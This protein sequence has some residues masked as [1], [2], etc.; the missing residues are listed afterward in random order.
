MSKN[1]QPVQVIQPQQALCPA[2]MSVPHA[3]SFLPLDFME[4]SVLT[5]HQLHLSEDTFTDSLFWSEDFN[6]PLIKA[7]Y[8]RSY[9]DVN[10]E[11]F[12]LTKK[13]F[14]KELP[15]FINHCSQKAAKGFGTIPEK[16][17]RGMKIYKQKITFDEARKRIDGVYKPFHNSLTSLIKETQAKFGKCFLLD[18]H[19]MP[20]RKGR[21]NFDI[22]I[23]NNFGTSCSYEHSRILQDLCQSQGF[24]VT[25]N[26]PFSGGYTVCHY[27]CPELG[28][29][30]VQIEVL[31]SL[32]MNEETLKKT[33]NFAEIQNRLHTVI[34]QFT[35]IL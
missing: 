25:F 29:S 26:N 15:V 8:S 22:I 13:M 24:S 1:V 3:G 21:K 11:P 9:V 4:M 12:E 17:R 31:R 7:N 10:R 5:P 2:V 19:S 30:A 23:S 20:F 28:I 27:G 14:K 32:Y 33:Q 34:K 6:F 18:C 35:D 16:I